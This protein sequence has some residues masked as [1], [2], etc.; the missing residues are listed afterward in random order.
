MTMNGNGC[1][2]N[3]ALGYDYML[4]ASK[5]GDYPSLLNIGQLF[6][7]GTYVKKDPQ[8]AAAWFILSHRMAQWKQSRS[9]SRSRIISRKMNSK[10]SWRGLRLAS[11]V[12]ARSLTSDD[13]SPGAR[14]R[15]RSAG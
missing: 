9:S 12:Y 1:P 14:H 2:K 3:E 15:E 6:L 8:E 11:P 7:D 10:E 13:L 4:R 5:M